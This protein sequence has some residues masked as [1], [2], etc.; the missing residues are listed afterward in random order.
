MPGLCE[1]TERQT[2][3]TGGGVGVRPLLKYPKV[4]MFDVF[5]VCLICV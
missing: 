2:D 1:Q 4:S 3:R 5:D